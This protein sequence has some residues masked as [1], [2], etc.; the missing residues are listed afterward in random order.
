MSDAGLMDR[1]REQSLLPSLMGQQVYSGPWEAVLQFS[2]IDKGAPRRSRE[3]Y[4][5]CEVALKQGGKN[6]KEWG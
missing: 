6:E 1:T 3:A 2:F 4:R 5:A